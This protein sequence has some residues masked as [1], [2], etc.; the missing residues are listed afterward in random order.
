M[1]DASLKK[2][3]INPFVSVLMSVYSEKPDIL[4]E[5][6]DSIL[7]QSYSNF[8]FLI[9]LD[10]PD[11]AELW[12]FLCH[13]AEQDSRIIIRKNKTNRLLAGTLND[14]LLIAK[15]EYMVR[16]DGDDISVKYRIKCLVEYMEK[17]PDVGV[18]SSWMKAFGHKK[19][20]QNR[21]VRYS[22]DFDEMKC[23]MLYQTPIAHAPCIIRRSVVDR[24]GPA[25]YNERCCKTQDYELWSR[26]IEGGV[27]FGMV[28]EPLYLRRVSHGDGPEPIKY[29]VI[30]NQVAR[31]NMT[32]ILSQVKIALPEKVSV[33][34]INP[35]RTA[36]N[37]TSG[38]LNKQLQIIQCMLYSNIYDNAVKRVLV[39]LRNGDIRCLT[40]LSSEMKLQFC[41]SKK[42]TEM[43]N[44]VTSPNELIYA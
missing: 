28:P 15:G 3:Q 10:K 12:Q 42:L 14:E 19:W 23:M 26:L 11:N 6:I 27:I 37:S 32:S 29:Q 2:D 25:L 4:K 40:A 43:N 1:S 31:H 35:I 38:L 16:M 39:M 8:E 34:M 33:E 41:R 13:C 7:Y 36:I 24:Y 18:A 20:Y 21:V 30:H 5:C 22:S 44:M 17:H 9:F